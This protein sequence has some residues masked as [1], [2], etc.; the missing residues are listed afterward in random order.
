MDHSVLPGVSNVEIFYRKKLYSM[1]VNSQWRQGKIFVNFL[2]T[3]NTNDAS[4]PGDARYYSEEDGGV[5]YTYH[6]H[7]DGK[8]KGHLDKP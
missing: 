1:Y 7:E 5:Y 2:R 4:G 3:N 8:L 6:Y